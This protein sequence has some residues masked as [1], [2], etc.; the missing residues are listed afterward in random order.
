ML[1]HAWQSDERLGSHEPQYLAMGSEAACGHQ[2]GA[3]T[4]MYGNHES[5]GVVRVVWCGVM[6]CMALVLG[7]EAM[8]STAMSSMHVP[9]VSAVCCSLC[10]LPAAAESDHQPAVQPAPAQAACWHPS[11]RPAAAAAACTQRSDQPVRRMGIGSSCSNTAPAAPASPHPLI[12]KVGQL[13]VREGELR[14]A[15][16]LA[17]LLNDS[18]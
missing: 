15:G 7:E 6:Y 3:S 14:C 13:H 18:H 4:E 5:L 10:L 12:S 2:P 11:C 8:R 9:A 1:L 16:G 17:P